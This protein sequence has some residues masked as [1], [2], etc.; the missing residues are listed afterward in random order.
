[1]KANDKDQ[2]RVQDSERTLGCGQ[3][4]LSC[5]DEVRCTDG[6]ADQD[7]VSEEE[8]S[9]TNIYAVLAYFKNLRGNKDPRKNVSLCPLMSFLTTGEE[10][11][12]IFL[13]HFHRGNVLSP[14]FGGDRG[15]QKPNPVTICSIMHFSKKKRKKKKKK[16][17][18]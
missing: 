16:F 1:M 10:N 12:I 3:N 18:A 8:T 9:L 4:I 13:S 6:A 17:E 11:H 14:Q 2:Y 5:T 7:G 15:G